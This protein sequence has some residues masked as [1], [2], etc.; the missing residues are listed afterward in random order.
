MKPQRISDQCVQ[1][2]QQLE[3]LFKL[4]LPVR[5]STTKTVLILYHR[6]K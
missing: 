5:M 3:E 1:Y 2:G 6:S 4:L